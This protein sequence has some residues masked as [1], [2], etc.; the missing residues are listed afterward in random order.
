MLDIDWIL[1]DRY[2]PLDIV[3]LPSARTSTS[4]RPISTISLDSGRG[5]SA[6]DAVTPRKDGQG[7]AM[8]AGQ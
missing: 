1:D 2:H 5:E 8:D 4:G 7:S 3:P 6:M